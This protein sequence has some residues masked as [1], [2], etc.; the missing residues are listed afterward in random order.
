MNAADDN[1]R[2][3]ENRHLTKKFGRISLKA[4]TF[5]I[6]WRTNTRFAYTIGINES[7]GVELIL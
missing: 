6:I 5:Y 1:G 7:I 4:G 3:E 2:T